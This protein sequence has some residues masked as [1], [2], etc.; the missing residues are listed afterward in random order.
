[1]LTVSH[2]GC[3]KLDRDVKMLDLSFRVISEF[4]RGLATI[5]ALFEK[6]DD[7]PR[8][9]ELDWGKFNSLNTSTYCFSTIQLY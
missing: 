9:F 8:D 5:D 6:H 1:M 4:D 7:T 2:P 3:E